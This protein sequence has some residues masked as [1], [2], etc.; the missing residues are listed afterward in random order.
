MGFELYLRKMEAIAIIP[1]KHAQRILSCSAKQ[2]V[3]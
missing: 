2:Y 3:L 1:M